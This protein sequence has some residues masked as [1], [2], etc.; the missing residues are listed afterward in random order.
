VSERVLLIEDD[1]KLANQV[2]A[3]LSDGGFAPTWVRDGQEALAANP[4]SFSLLVLDLMLPGLHGLDV[5]KQVR[6]ESDVPVLVL[7]ARNDTTDKVRALELGA[8]DYLTKP[9]WPEELLA[10]VHARLRRPAL[11]RSGLIQIGDLAIDLAGRR[12]QVRGESVE[13]TRVEFD[14]LAALAR[15]PGAA[16]TR[17]WLLENV[18]DPERDG[19]ERT[20]DVHVSRLRKKLGPS[21][22]CVATVWGVGYRLETPAE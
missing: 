1:E 9:F 5:L 12:I 18:L 22:A 7:S 14:L 4:R 20:L 10:R 13:L 19:T 15:R 6:R 16:I 2:L 17:T 21:A 3:C 8:D 11:Q